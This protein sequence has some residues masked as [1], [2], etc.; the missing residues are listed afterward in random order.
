M[1]DG[2]TNAQRAKRRRA[3][4]NPS[5]DQPI[6]ADDLRLLQSLPGS[7]TWPAASLGLR[8]FRFLA[9]GHTGVVYVADYS[10]AGLFFR[11]RVAIKVCRDGGAGQEERWLRRCNAL[12]IG[13]PLV[14]A[15][16]ACVVMESTSKVRASARL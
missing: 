6:N 14:M 8:D 4:P 12:G 2:G 16:D 9:R 7:T 15:E 5:E 13:A 11:R 10:V 1:A 3:A